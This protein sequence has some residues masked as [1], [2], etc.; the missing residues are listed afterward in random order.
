MEKEES[1]IIA[2]CK[3][4][5]ELLHNFKDMEQRHWPVIEEAVYHSLH[6]EA[7]DRE[8]H[9]ARARIKHA[10]RFAGDH[11]PLTRRKIS[12]LHVL[13]EYLLMYIYLGPQQTIGHGQSA[14]MLRPEMA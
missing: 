4:H 8:L 12:L 11:F 9:E 6:L 3:A 2:A 1:D 7:I 10:V 14:L 13:V 5:N